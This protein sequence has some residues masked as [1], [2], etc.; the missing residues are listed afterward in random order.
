MKTVYKLFVL[1]LITAS[2]LAQSRVTILIDMKNPGGEIPKNFIGESF[3]T[4]SIRINNQG[5]KGYL[6]DST[7][8]QLITI[9]KNL[10]MKSLRIGGSSVDLAAQQ[11]TYADIDA[12]FRFAKSAGV[13]VIYT[14]RL[15]NGN[16]E[17]EAAVAKYIWKKYSPQLDGFAIG[18]E[19]D[20]HI[21]HIKDP[22][23]YETTPGVLGTA[24]PSYLKKWRKIASTVLDSVPEAKFS[25]PNTGSNYP[26]P[27]AR[28]TEYN[29]KSWTVNFIDSEKNSGIISFFTQHNYVGQST[30][31]KTKEEVVNMMLSSK[32]DTVNY[33]LLY[34]ADCV[35]SLEADFPYRLTE[36]NCFSG[37]IDGAN[38][39]FAT[40]L[41]ALDYLHWWAEHKALGINFH[42]TEWRYN[43]TIRK[44]A[45][46]N[47][48]INPMGYG[49]AAFKVGGH[50]KILPV[51]INNPVN[52]NITSYAVLD[53]NYLYV[54]IINREHGSNAQNA[55]I[56]IKS[57]DKYRNAKV[58][59]L[60]SENNNVYAK[61]G[62][63]LGGVEITNHKQW[64]G[65]WAKIIPADPDKLNVKVSTAT[66]AI[67]RIQIE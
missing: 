17:E 41:Y 6:F 56:T 2:V 5:V 23:I 35:P 61:A 31:D 47:V 15:T 49:I 43:A 12:L 54:T 20:G 16:A 11:P 30:D 62:I 4:A 13:K 66:A 27:F 22:E 1:C 45:E 58:I 32:W 14:L 50:G 28:N 51:E 29:G 48:S 59:Y 64:H 40:A 36:S 42:S 38:N 44:D 25:G 55:D 39:T 18:N 19:P 67:L 9:F 63:T 46:G 52:L 10:G 33:P 57:G 53:S 8:H 26:V 7:D 60:T 34:N 37:G 3:E 65:K 21:Y 24:F